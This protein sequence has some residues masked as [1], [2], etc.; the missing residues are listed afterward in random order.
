MDHKLHGGSCFYV[1]ISSS[2]IICWKDCPFDICQK[3]VCHIYVGLFLPDLFHWTLCLSRCCYHFDYCDFI[4]SHEARSCYPSKF[5]LRLWPIR[6]WL[7]YWLSIYCLSARDLS[8]FSLLC[9]NVSGPLNVFLLPA[10]TVLSF[11]NRECWRD[12]AGEFCFLVLVCLLCGLQQH[13][14]LL[15]CQPT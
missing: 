12:I 5:I 2:S 4:R 11:V 3:S 6:Y 15:Q 7:L 8:F 10:C 9:E 13:T 14:H 1:V